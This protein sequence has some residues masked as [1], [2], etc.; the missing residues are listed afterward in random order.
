VTIM[1]KMKSEA[2]IWI[3]ADVKGLVALFERE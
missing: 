1:A 2:S 3:A